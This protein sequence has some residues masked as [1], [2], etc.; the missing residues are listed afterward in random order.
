MS[1]SHYIPREEAARILRRAQRSV[2]SL[3]D[4]LAEEAA[5]R[6][7]GVTSE[8]EAEAILETEV[9]KMLRALDAVERDIRNEL[10]AATIEED[11][12]G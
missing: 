3:G 6:C 12:D 9:E 5:A 11:D 7:A 10:G 1:R 4:V 2:L 8:A